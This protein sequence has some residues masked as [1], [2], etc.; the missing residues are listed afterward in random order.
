MSETE[1]KHVSSAVLRNEYKEMLEEHKN[2]S[3]PQDDWSREQITQ[4]KLGMMQFDRSFAAGRTLCS[5][6][7]AEEEID[8]LRVELK[9]LRGQK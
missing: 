3:I 8:R 2:I 6:E 7:I 5:L 1:Y 9:L 4:Y